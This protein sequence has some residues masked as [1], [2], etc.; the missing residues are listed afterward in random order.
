MSYTVLNDPA[1][2]EK[3]YIHAINYYLENTNYNIVFCN[4]SGEDI[5]QKLPKNRRLECLSFYGND[6]DSSIGKGFGEIQIIQYALEH[7]H[8]IK[9]TKYIIKITGRLIISNLHQAIKTTNFI[10]PFINN[11]LYLSEI[12]NAHK[13]IDS[14][15]FISSRELYT[16]LINQKYKLNDTKGYYFEHLLYNICNN[17][18]VSFNIC[19]IFPQFKFSG[20]SGSTGAVYYYEKETKSQYL[21]NL[22]EYCQTYKYKKEITIYSRFFIILI[23]NI[24]RCL[25]IIQRRIISP[26]V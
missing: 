1:E 17:T 15:C 8:F 26:N 11:K 18:E 21:Y 3:Q 9:Q 10:W 20:I 4:N 22:R 14:R 16:E 23:S 12:N 13:F 24:V 7:S 19:F 25:R 5:S 2:R 6:Y